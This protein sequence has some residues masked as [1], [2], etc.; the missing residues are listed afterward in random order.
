[1]FYEVNSSYR[2]STSIDPAR[3]RCL[4]ELS[5][6]VASHP[7]FGPLEHRGEPRPIADLETHNRFGFGYA[8]AVD[9]WPLRENG[10]TIIVPATGRVQA[11]DG[12]DLRNLGHRAI[13]ASPQIGRQSWNVVEP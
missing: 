9:G 5:S 12:E 13:A 6:S 8:R 10:E 7:P 3:W 4:F 1:M 2:H 11:S